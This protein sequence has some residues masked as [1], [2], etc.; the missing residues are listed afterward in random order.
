MTQATLYFQPQNKEDLLFLAGYFMGRIYS[1]H[2]NALEV[3]AMLDNQA[4]LIAAM[5]AETKAEFKEQALEFQEFWLPILQRDNFHIAKRF[6]EFL[7]TL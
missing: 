5:D 7:N 3:P 6:V 2:T 1:P 4:A